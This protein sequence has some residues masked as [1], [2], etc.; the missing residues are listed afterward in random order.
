[1]AEATQNLDIIEDEVSGSDSEGFKGLMDPQTANNGVYNTVYM[2]ICVCICMC[3][4]CM[5]VHN[6]CMC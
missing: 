6:V 5:C 4:N 3:A 1:L 2:C